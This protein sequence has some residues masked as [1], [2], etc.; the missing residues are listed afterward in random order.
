MIQAM[1]APVS[2]SR[3]EGRF[4]R[5]WIIPL[6]G[7]DYLRVRR[8]CRVLGLDTMKELARLKGSPASGLEYKTTPNRLSPVA[9]LPIAAARVWL[10]SGL[11]G[12]HVSPR[13]RAL[14]DEAQRDLIRAAAMMSG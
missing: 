8:A 7:T 12:R 1:L 14:L 4:P 3:P 13:V 6:D 2:A 9:V 5:K 11:D 10:G